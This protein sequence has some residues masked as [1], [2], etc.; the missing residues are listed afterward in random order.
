[1]NVVYKKVDEIIPYE[2]NPRINDAA[3]E[4]VAKSIKEFGFRVPLVLDKNNVIITGHTRLRSA[5]MLGMTEVPCIIADNLTPEQVQAYRIADNRTGEIAEWDY[6]LLPLEIKELQNA[7]F[8][9]SLLGFDS[10]EL[11]KLLNG[12]EGDTLI[13]GETEPDTVP[14]VPEEAAS[15][16]GTVYQLGKHRLLCGDATKAEDVARLMGEEKANLWLTDPPYNVAYEGSNGMTI[17]NDNMEDA[18]FRKFLRDAFQCVHD[19]M[20]PGASFYIFHADSEGYNFRGAC[21]DI[22]LKVRQCLIWKKNALV[23]GRQDYQWL[24]E[25]CQPSGTIVWTEGNTRTPIEELKDGDRVMSFMRAGCEIT[26]YKKAGTGVPVKTAFRD[27]SGELYGI[28]SDGKITW[29]TP[30]HRFAIRF[31]SEFKDCWCT[32]LM[33]RGRLWRVGMC[34]MFNQLGCGIKIR[35]KQEKADA[36]WILGIFK[37]RSDASAA[38]HATAIRYGIPMTYWETERGMKERKDTWRDKNHI[39]QIYMRLDMEQMNRNAHNLLKMY[40]RLY[41]IPFMTRELC[42]DKFSRRVITLVPACNILPEVMEIPVPYE[43]WDMDNNKTYSW[44]SIDAVKHRDYQ[45]KVYSLDVE[46]HHFYI[47]DGLLTHNCLYGWKDGAAHAWYND[48][49]QTTVMEFDKPKHNDVHPT[50]KPVEM[51][52]YLIKNS[53][54][55]GEIVIDT[56]GGSGSTLIA[57]E[58]TGRLCRT[59]ELDPKYCDVIRRRWAE[60][61]AGEGC[62]WQSLTPPI[63]EKHSTEIVN[64]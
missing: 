34:R 17:E 59:M 28:S 40:H 15:V 56:F 9:L 35:L 43:H 36:A 24:H 16:P 48:R 26:G 53:S 49:S 63:T 11:D 50:M 64:L 41:E 13:D 37:T 25:P 29:T 21:H 7:D 31:K 55:R 46:K 62:D 14:E 33:K 30:E 61:T 20:E 39:M 19:R 58:Q 5:K 1:M 4:A 52:V 8:D 22:G 27:Y 60:F 2:K 47:A 12:E 57:C 51:L 42:R 18:Q 6:S 3:V 23:L 38:E 32:Y 10:D 45:G 54:K 44:Q